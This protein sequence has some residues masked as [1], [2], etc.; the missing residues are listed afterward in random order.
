MKKTARARNKTRAQSLIVPRFTAVFSPDTA[1]RE[2][3]PLS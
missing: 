1:I 3:T 2:I